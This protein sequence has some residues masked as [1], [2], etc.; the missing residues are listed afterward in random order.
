[1][2]IKSCLKTSLYSPRDLDTGLDQTFLLQYMKLELGRADSFWARVLSPKM[3]LRLTPKRRLGL[4]C[5]IVNS[6]N[7]GDKPSSTWNDF[8]RFNNDNYFYFVGGIGHYYL[9][10]SQTLGSFI[11]DVTQSDTSA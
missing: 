8:S 5:Y 3:G 9:F 10:G 7:I 4:A 11:K 6:P 2:L 1:M